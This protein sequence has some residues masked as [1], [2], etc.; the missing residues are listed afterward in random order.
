MTLPV[1]EQV[2][3]EQTGDEAEEKEFYSP[4]TPVSPTAAAVAG[5]VAT[6]SVVGAISTAGQVAP[7]VTT[8]AFA[9]TTGVSAMVIMGPVGWVVCGAAATVV[10][11][12]GLYRYFSQPSPLAVNGS[13]P[14]SWSWG[15]LPNISVRKEWTKHAMALYAQLGPVQ[16]N[17]KYLKHLMNNADMNA[18]MMV[19]L[20]SQCVAIAALAIAS[21]TSGV[22]DVQID[23]VL[24]K[25]GFGKPFLYHLTVVNAQFYDM[26]VKK[27]KKKVLFWLKSVP[28]AEKFYLS[29]GFTKDA[30][31]GSGLVPMSLVKTI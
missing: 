2:F 24:A 7:A 9:E 23:G 11:G 6:A 28:K 31:D 26:C 13:A 19:K 10:T 3:F 14:Q 4:P 29:C 12:Y 8:M 17:P 15:W 18:F 1:V 27:G 5:S 16:L 20:G 25:P 21:K 30:A 22:L